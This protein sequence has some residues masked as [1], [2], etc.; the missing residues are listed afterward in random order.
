VRRLPVY[1]V[2]DVSESMVG[3]NIKKLDDGLNSI[4][5]SLRQDP[6]ALETVYVSIIA[7]AGKAKTIVPLI[8]IASFYS[9]RLPIGGG[10]SLGGG[11]FHL[12]AELDKSIVKTTPEQKGDWKPIIYLITDGK[13]TDSVESAIAKWKSEYANR[14]TFVAISLGRFADIAVLKQITENVMILENTQNEDFKKFIAWVTDSVK[15][16]SK[17]VVDRFIDGSTLAK[18]DE[19]VLTL[20]KDNVNDLLTIDPNY[21]IITARCQRTRAPYLM[22]YERNV[23]EVKLK[24]LSIDISNY[25]ISGCYV[26]EDEYFAFSDGKSE[27]LKVNTSQLLGTPSCPHCGN[28]AGFGMCKCGGIMCMSESNVAICPWCEEEIHFRISGDGDFDISRAK[29]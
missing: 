3:E 16:Q 14:A 22:K 23:Q 18:F 15:S 19:N 20:V 7:F 8:E 9:P 6:H 25:V 28:N 26:V 2:L 17:S 29:G 12:M 27:E 4:I 13:P 21:V 11:L 5:R 1:F 10:T 24:D